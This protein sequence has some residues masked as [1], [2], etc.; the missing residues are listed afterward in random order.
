MMET[1]N[2]HLWSNEAGEDC[3]ADGA[4]DGS[5]KEWRVRLDLR[6]EQR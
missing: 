6:E 2:D 3:A 1:S 4:G 5:H